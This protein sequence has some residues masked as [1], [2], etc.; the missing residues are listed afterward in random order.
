MNK[1]LVLPQKTLFNLKGKKMVTIKDFEINH[2]KA[3][4]MD[5][6]FTHD[7]IAMT[8]DNKDIDNKFFQ[9]NPKLYDCKVLPG[10]KYS[11]YYGAGNG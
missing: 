9:T 10:R 7:G 1:A 6:V 4:G 2:A 5:I 8:V 11:I 3:E